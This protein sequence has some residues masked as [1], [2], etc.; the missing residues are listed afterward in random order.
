MTIYNI[1][2]F[3]NLRNQWGDILR[4]APTDELLSALTHKYF[5]YKVKG[6][7]VQSQFGWNE[8]KPGCYHNE[9]GDQIIII[10]AGQ[11]ESELVR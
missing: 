8:K 11:N 5:D 1:V 10:P 3:L 7:I 6:T 2:C 4:I 9:A